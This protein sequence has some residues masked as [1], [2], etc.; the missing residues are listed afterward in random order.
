M[1]RKWEVLQGRL[2]YKVHYQMVS[3]ADYL[4][5]EDND[6]LVLKQ[7][8]TTQIVNSAA[9]L[10]VLETPQENAPEPKD[11]TST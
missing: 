7:H 1:S 10:S 5:S 2:S 8:Y 6:L 9:F 11:K 3:K 4:V